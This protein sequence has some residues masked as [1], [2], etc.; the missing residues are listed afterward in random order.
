[1]LLEAVAVK[2]SKMITLRHLLPKDYPACAQIYKEGMDTGIATFETIVPDWNTWDRK[3]L[4][5][6]RFVAIEMDEVVGWIGLTSFT[7]RAVY[8]GVAEVTLYIAQKARKKGIGEALLMKCVDTSEKE[9]FWTVQAKIFA[10]NTK[11]L[12]LFKK[13]GFRKVG[14]REKLGMRLGVWYDN[15]LMERRAQ[16]ST[17]K[18]EIL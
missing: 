3:F 11:S 10:V 4:K 14:V 2:K 18:V 7:D 13:C 12:N 5:K 8:K 15:V 16:S 9:G 17:E 1:V 6:C